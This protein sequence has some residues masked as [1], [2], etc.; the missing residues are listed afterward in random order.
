MRHLLEYLLL[1]LLPNFGF[2]LSLASQDC[3][4]AP[5][6]NG[7]SEELLPVTSVPLQD[8]E[9]VRTN[10]VAATVRTPSQVG[11]PSSSKQT[12]PPL[13]LPRDS[14]ASPANDSSESNDGYR[15]A[16]YYVNWV[17]DNR[18]PT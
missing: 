12:L 13:P 6:A 15:A 7:C 14:I 5:R 10:V 9:Q 4:K 1:T 16:A 11:L 2:C 3:V 8:L 18:A 17:S